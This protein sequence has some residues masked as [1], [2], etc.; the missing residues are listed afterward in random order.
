MFCSETTKLN[1][2]VCLPL[3][4]TSKCSHKFSMCS[5]LYPSLER[6][7]LKG[8]RIQSKLAVSAIAAIAGS[9]KQSIF[10]KLCKV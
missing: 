1:Y 9:S 2:K 3:H 7:C 10:T 4:V 8:T 6:I 5:D